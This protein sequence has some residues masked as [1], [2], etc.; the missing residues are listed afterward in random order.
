MGADGDLGIYLGQPV[1][2][3][4]KW[5]ARQRERQKLK[6]SRLRKMVTKNAV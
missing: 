4:K 1:D 6:S 3:L 5:R 2:Y